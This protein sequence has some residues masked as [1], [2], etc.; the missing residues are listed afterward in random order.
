MV[1]IC[2]FYVGLSTLHVKFNLVFVLK[3]SYL[4][5]KALLCA[6]V[7]RMSALSLCARVF[8]RVCMTMC[9]C[10]CA[11]V[12]LRT[13]VCACACDNSLCLA[14]DGVAACWLHPGQHE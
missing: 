2:K 12:C 9:L 7:L 4:C 1:A 3:Y 11:C 14:G 5:F 10:T 13:C 6:D 8:M